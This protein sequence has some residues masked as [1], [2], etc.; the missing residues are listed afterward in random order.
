MTA[1]ILK[2]QYNRT[3]L[4]GKVEVLCTGAMMKIKGQTKTKL[5]SVAPMI[6]DPSPTSA[7]T[8]FEKQKL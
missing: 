6:T 4:K 3:Q 1:L 8:L 2:Q 5:D 7:T